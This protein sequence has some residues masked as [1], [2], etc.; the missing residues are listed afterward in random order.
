VTTSTLA[1]MEWAM[2]RMAASGDQALHFQPST[3]E[4]AQLEENHVEA[5]RYE[6]TCYQTG[7]PFC[8]PSAIRVNGTETSASRL[9]H[10]RVQLTHNSTPELSCT[11]TPFTPLPGDRPVFMNFKEF[12][13]GV[14][15]NLDRDAK[16]P[17]FP[18]VIKIHHFWQLIR[19][20]WLSQSGRKHLQE[21]ERHQSASNKK[22]Q[23][24]GTRS[25]WE[26]GLGG[27]MCGLVGRLRRNYCVSSGLAHCSDVTTAI[28]FIMRQI[29]PLNTELNPI[30]Q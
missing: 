24:C 25:E 27:G 29:N 12:C 20:F 2:W 17:G 26:R 15:Q 21:W 30:C 16:C 4:M 3:D 22:E 7:D 1:T 9:L 19:I 14:P 5:E 28:L 11:G 6:R 10:R 8:M 18:Q 23:H 13:H